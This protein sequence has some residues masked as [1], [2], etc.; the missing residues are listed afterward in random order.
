MRARSFVSSSVSYLR[1]EGSV[2]GWPGGATEIPARLGQ[3][4]CYSQQASA[5]Y[6]CRVRRSEQPSRRA[7]SDEGSCVDPDR[8]AGARAMQMQPTGLGWLRR[9]M[10][11]E[12]Q[13]GWGDGCG[14]SA[15]AGLRSGQVSVQSKGRLPLSSSS[16]FVVSPRSGGARLTE[17][18]AGRLVKRRLEWLTRSARS[19]LK[20]QGLVQ[21]EY[22]VSHSK[23]E[24]NNLWSGRTSAGWRRRAAE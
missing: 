10:P 1:G 22:G 9:Q 7:P 19:S 14:E 13:A 24:D 3:V 21:S 6:S 17:I 2:K 18:R 15:A 23:N 16:A 11:S 8:G 20:Y 4:T 5:R 12:V